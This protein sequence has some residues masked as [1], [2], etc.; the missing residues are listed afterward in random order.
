MAVM[1][2]DYL[3]LLEL[4]D[5]SLWRCPTA[6]DLR[7]YP[8]YYCYYWIILCLCAVIGFMYLILFVAVAVAVVV[9]VAVELEMQMS[10]LFV[11][12]CYYYVLH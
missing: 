3:L 2:P 6:L 9:D 12:L 8:D 7:M 4:A 10:V 5:F 11:H 1:H